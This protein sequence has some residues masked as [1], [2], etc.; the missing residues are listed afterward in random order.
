MFPG[1]ERETEHVKQN[2]KKKIKKKEEE[3]EEIHINL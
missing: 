1:E 3:E 2:K